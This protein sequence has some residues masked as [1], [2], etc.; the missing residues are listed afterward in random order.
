M[1][2]SGLREPV[3]TRC[4]WPASSQCFEF[5][6]DYLLTHEGIFLKKLIIIVWL[7]DWVYKLQASVSAIWGLVVFDD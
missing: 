1:A 7:H 5:L 4:L 3:R 2:G 6:L